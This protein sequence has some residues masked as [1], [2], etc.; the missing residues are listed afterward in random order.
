MKPKIILITGASS[1]IGYQTAVEL[2][3][4]GHRVYGAARRVEKMEGLKAYGVTPL[5]M[6][7]TDEQ[8]ISEALDALV[9]KEGRID[10]LI[11]NAG[12]GSFGAM[13]D[14]PIV[15]ARRQFEVNVFG[16]VRLTQQVLPYLRRQRSGRIIITGS[17]GGKMV[18]FFGGWYHAT[19]YALEALSD[20]LRMETKGFGIDVVLLE[21][22]CIKTD[23]GLIAADN[24]ENSSRGGAYADLAAQT[25]A[26]LRKLYSGKLMSHPKVISR[27][28]RK[29][30]NS[31]RPRTRYLV[32]AGAKPVVF[33]HAI[34]PAP[35]FD[36]L[37]MHVV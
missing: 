9:S 17:M 27:A 12:Y 3:Q 32:G 19:K 33:L 2:A 18:S 22:G 6:D 11:N 26:G 4:Q 30:V 8:S 36:W 35:W 16:L 29:A 31:R 14:V 15:E 23:W 37:M 28:M 7:I 25:A 10:V 21:P 5:K 20:A 24:L 34:L 1:G 13:E